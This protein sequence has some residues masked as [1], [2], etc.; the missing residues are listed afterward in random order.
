MMTSP[1]QFTLG[2]DLAQ[3]SFHAAI[4][5]DPNQLESWRKLPNAA[6][7]HP[8][9]SRQAILALMDWL[10]RVCPEGTCQ[11]VVVESTGPISLRFA[12][13]AAATPGLPAPAIVNPAQVRHFGKS[14]GV[15][16]KTD[17]VD[18]CV[19]ALFGVVHRPAPTAMRSQ[20]EQELRELCR[21]RESL[22]A[23]RTAV[24]NELKAASHASVIGL[25]G[26]EM[27]AVEKRIEQVEQAVEKSIA[28]SDVCSK[29]VR[30]LSQIKGIGKVTATTLTAELGDLRQWGRNQLV[31]M[32]GVFP[33][34]RESG[35]SVWS[36][37]RMAKGGGHRLR[38]VL[39]MCATAILQSKG[40]LR[41]Y[42]ERLRAR[43]MKCMW[44]I[45]ALMRKL[46]LIA[47]AVMVNGGKY[48]PAQICR[49]SEA[50]P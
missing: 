15:R 38:R 42:A 8:P 28:A 1:A 12:A 29:Q 41:D 43:G 45:G 26:A 24:G 21:L 35:N 36:P 37:P 7:A 14:L 5:S 4:A 6:F 46:L 23:R 40:P 27:E 3:N 49:K 47:R 31:G 10:Q 17:A 22:V 39:Y 25:L 2:L 19:I 9:H 32:A 20:A 50:T 18:A 11:A 13:Q 30:A 34:R 44:V 16:E 33:R 48:D